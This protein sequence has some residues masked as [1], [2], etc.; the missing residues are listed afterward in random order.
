[1]LID[2]SS[3]IF[4]DVAGARLFIQVSNNMLQ[5]SLYRVISISLCTVS[6]SL[7]VFV[8]L[9]MC[10]EC[11]KVGVHVYLANCNGK[12]YLSE[13]FLPQWFSLL[14]SLFILLFLLNMMIHLSTFTCIQRI[15]IND[16][17]PLREHPKDSHIKRINELHEPST[18]FRHC[19]WRC[20]VYS[21]AEGKLESRNVHRYTKSHDF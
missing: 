17:S 2:C 18:Y 21:A 19:S 3:V 15:L 11:Q 10:T 13:T 6:V 4:V 5:N 20:N 9:Q 7:I 1:M 12:A 16:S 8:F 14:C